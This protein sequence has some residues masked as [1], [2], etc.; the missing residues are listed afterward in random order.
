MG[1]FQFVRLYST[2]HGELYYLKHPCFDG[3]VVGMENPPQHI[4]R[5]C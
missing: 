4:Q 3:N 2:L 5:V 1:K